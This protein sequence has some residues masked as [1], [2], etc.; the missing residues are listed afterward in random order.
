MIKIIIIYFTYNKN[1]TAIWLWVS[2]NK[3]KGKFYSA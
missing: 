2:L 1:L 3:S